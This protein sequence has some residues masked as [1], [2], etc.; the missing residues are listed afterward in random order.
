MANNALISPTPAGLFETYGERIRAHAV[1]IQV[2]DAGGKYYF[3][4]DSILRG[5]KIVGCTYPEPVFNLQ[6]SAYVTQNSPL[7][8]RPL[9]GLL[10]L[11]S[12]F[13]NLMDG[14]NILFQQVPLSQFFITQTD[15]TIQQIFTKTFDPQQSFIQVGLPATNVTTGTSYLF[16]FYYL[17]K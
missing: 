15:R 4:D 5:Y 8:Q 6:T 3:P 13:L 11:A 1:E 16:E 17:T 10:Q 12:S 7:T 14:E 2:A 9:A